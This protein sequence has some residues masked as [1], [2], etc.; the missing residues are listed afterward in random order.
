MMLGLQFISV[1]HVSFCL[2]RGPRAVVDLLPQ[3]LECWGLQVCTTVIVPG[4]YRCAPLLL[5]LEIT[6]VHHCSCSWGLQECTTISVFSGL[7]LA[8]V[9]TGVSKHR[10][11]GLLF[12]DSCS[13]FDC[14]GFRHVLYSRGCVTFLLG[15]SVYL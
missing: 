13:V 9:T 7:C 15:A 8:R 10:V 2:E 3:P 14:Q 5:F 6:C 4:G 12:S 1:F 11:W